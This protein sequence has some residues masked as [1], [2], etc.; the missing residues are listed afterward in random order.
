MTVESNFWNWFVQ[1]ES[2][3]FAFDPNQNF[4]REKLFGGLASE[5]QRVHPDLTFEFGP[6]GDTRELVISAAG[7]KEAFPAVVSLTRAAPTFDR[8]RF[9]AFRPRR[10]PI[11]IVQIGD[12]RIDPRDVQFTLL[13]NGRIAGIHL[14]MPGFR[15]DHTRFEQIGYL[16]LD[17]ALGEYDVEMRLGLIKM[18]STAVPTAGTRYAL[19][20]LPA[21]FD[22]LTARLD[23][24]GPKPS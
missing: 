24:R 17:E 9:T 20:E 2:D 16:L 13:D 23:G 19:P 14:F 11:N 22:E 5:L 12:L 3:L 8:W 7:I 6:P 15:K 10:S 21:R 1:H 18:L 4:E